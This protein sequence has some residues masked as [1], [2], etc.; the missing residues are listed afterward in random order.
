MDE[1]KS[2]SFIR[3]YLRHVV[4]IIVHH[5]FSSNRINS[6]EDGQFEMTQKSSTTREKTDYDANMMNNLMT[7]ETLRNCFVNKSFCGLDELKYID[8]VDEK[9]LIKDKNGKTH[10]VTA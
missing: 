10:S 2:L 1:L 3:N 6:G 5:A 7:E 8:A 4:S 9:D